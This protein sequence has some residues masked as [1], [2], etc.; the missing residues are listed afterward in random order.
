[1]MLDTFFE[2]GLDHHAY[3]IEGDVALSFDHLQKALIRLGYGGDMADTFVREYETILIDHARE[4]KDFQSETM[5][6]GA[7]KKLIILKA[8]SFSYPAQ[9][10]LLKVFE[11]PR[12]GVVFFLILADASKLFPT[13][14]SRLQGVV[15]EFAADEVM[16]KAAKTFMAGSIKERLAFIK[17]FTDMESK[18]LLKEKC[19]RLLS[20]IE[21]ELARGNVS[22]DKK[23][24]EDVYLAKQ[25]IGD[26]GSS[27]K[28][29]LEHLA[30]TI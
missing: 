26:Q 14:R 24:V 12:D 11:E 17:K 2:N 16:K 4:I 1:M 20:E 3:L 23:K 7:K 5:R 22:A 13:L 25:Y 6:S 27:P 21:H 15:G 9:N 8:L 18:Q 28:I 10:A 29:L 30:V 19:M